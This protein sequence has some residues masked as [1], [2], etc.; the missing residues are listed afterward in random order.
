MLITGTTFDDNL[1]GNTGN[2]T[3]NGIGL[4][5]NN[6]ELDQ[7]TGGLGADTFV[8]GNLAGAYYLNPLGLGEESYAT[9]TDFSAR[10][11]DKFE[12]TGTRADYELEIFQG[13]VDILFQGDL[14][15]NISNTTNIS[16]NRDFVFL[17]ETT[18]IPAIE[19]AQY[20]A[21]NSDLITA[22]NTLPYEQA[23][24]AADQHYI[25]FGIEENRPL[26]TFVEDR[27]LASNP[28]LIR[29]YG[30][31]QFLYQDALDL[32]TQ[33]YIQFGFSENRPLDTFNANSYLNNNPNLIP[34]FGNDLAGAT[35]HYIQIGFNQGLIV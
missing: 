8:L 27:Y 26:D 6:N 4:T 33:H 21:S 16:L 34:Q 3:L 32:A 5:F 12:V 28:D 15:A 10:Q 35:E 7:L 29:V 18:T 24:I 19:P 20:L 23:L 30:N 1:V 25:D 31:S 17:N 22:F 9:I 11:G 13:G 2:D 14:I